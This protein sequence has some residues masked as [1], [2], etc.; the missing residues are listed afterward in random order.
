MIEQSFKLVAETPNMELVIE[1]AARSCYKS[2]ASEGSAEK[3]ISRL[4]DR[5]HEAMLEFGDMHYCITTSIAIAREITRHRLCSFAQESTRYVTYHSFIMIEPELDGEELEIWQEAVD[6][7]CK[8]YTALL[9]KGVSPQHARGVLPLDLATTLH[10]KANIRE[11]RKIFSLRCDTAA[12]P[13]MRDLMS[14]ILADAETR[15]PYL[16]KG[17]LK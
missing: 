15:H 8:A 9:E 6:S 11:W 2:E 10:V 16:F 5:G 13:V 17:V 4:I 3:L 12:H 7:S 14:A 1:A